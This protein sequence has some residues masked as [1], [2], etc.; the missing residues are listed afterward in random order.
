MQHIRFKG[1]ESVQSNLNPHWLHEE[2]MGLSYYSVKQAYQ[3]QCAIYNGFDEVA[4]SIM[5]VSPGTHTIKTC[6]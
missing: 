4:E 2:E 1:I 5:T 6:K 3:H